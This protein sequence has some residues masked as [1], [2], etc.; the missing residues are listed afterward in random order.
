MCSVSTAPQQPPRKQATPLHTLHPC[1][2]E[3]NAAARQH[4]LHARKG[5]GGGQRQDQR[6]TS[7]ADGL[8]VP[9]S[10]V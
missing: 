6:N 1:I 4:T 10:C 2:T 3:H 7:H 8:S 5:Q 9:G